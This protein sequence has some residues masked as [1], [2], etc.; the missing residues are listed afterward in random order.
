MHS[1]QGKNFIKPSLLRQINI[2]F[3]VKISDKM[4][5]TPLKQYFKR[6]QSYLF[7]FFQNTE[8]FTLFKMP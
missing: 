1:Q 3:T 8:L 7:N 6:N 2:H 4:G 5:V